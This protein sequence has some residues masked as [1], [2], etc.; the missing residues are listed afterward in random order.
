MKKAS[1]TLYQRERNIW[2]SRESNP[3]E[4]KLQ[5]EALSTTPTLGQVIEMA[6][7]QSWLTLFRSG[8]PSTWSWSTWCSPSS[9]SRC[10]ASQST[11]P[12]SSNG[13]TA[14]ATASA[15][16]LDSSWHCLV[17]CG[18]WSKPQPDKWPL[19]WREDYDTNMVAS[20]SLIAI[21]CQ[22]NCDGHC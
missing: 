18:G 14:L 5:S 7:L 4:H 8:L 10:T 17:S 11:W 22:L 3:S 13:A 9:W 1:T 2:K 15:T 16:P 21:Y 12:A 19:N 20:R 6:S